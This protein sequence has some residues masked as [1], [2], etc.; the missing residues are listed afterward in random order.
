MY[1][2]T[3]LGFMLDSGNDDIVTIDVI[4]IFINFSHSFFP[5][6]TACYIFPL[7]TAVEALDTDKLLQDVKVLIQDPSKNCPACLNADDNKKNSQHTVYIEGTMVM[8]IG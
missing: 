5:L 1:D 4:I 8:D 2:V 3:I 7:C 6:S